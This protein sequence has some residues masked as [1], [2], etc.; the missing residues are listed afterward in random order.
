MYNLFMDN[1]SKKLNIF[2]Q[3][4]EIH[5]SYLMEGVEEIESARGLLNKKRFRVS[6]TNLTY[7]Q[8]NSLD[9][10][11]MLKDE[12]KENNGWRKFSLKEVI[13]LSVIKEVKNYGITNDQLENIKKSFFSKDYA[14]DTDECLLLI[15]NGVKIIMVLDK[16]FCV[17]FYTI[18]SYFVYQKNSKSF[19]NINLNEVFLETWERIGKKRV[20]YKNELDLL[21]GIVK[22][23]DTDEKEVELLKLIRNKDYKSIF[24]KKKDKNEFIVKGEKVELVKEN[25]LVKMIEDKDFADINIVKRDGN[26]VN[27]KVEENFKI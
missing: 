26:I 4:G 5:D 18:P 13:Y 1:N 10:N 23:F 20:E 7:R 14:F 25:D 19:I 2:F 16:D 12:R 15:L 27:I 6:D 21:A 9:N 8:V 24:I 11:N 17:S 22:D 3:F